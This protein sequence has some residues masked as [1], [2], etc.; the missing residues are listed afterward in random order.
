MAARN[1]RSGGHRLSTFTIGGGK[2]TSGAEQAGKKKG[3]LHEL[4]RHTCKQ[5][6]E[7]HLDYQLVPEEGKKEVALPQREL[8]GFFEN[9]GEEKLASRRWGGSQGVRERVLLSGLRKEKKTKKRKNGK[10]RAAAIR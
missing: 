6:A 8:W 1:G 2:K 7:K 3:H 4:V 9:S 10:T 5:M